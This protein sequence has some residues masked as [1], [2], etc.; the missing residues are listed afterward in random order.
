MTA[1]I[2][3]LTLGAPTVGTAQSVQPS[4]TTYT[5]L[6]EVVS[7][8]TT[9]RTMTVKPRVAYPEAASELKQFTP[10]ERVW[11]L[12]SGID[13][14]SD[15]VRQVR[16]AEPGR[17]IDQD[18]MLPAE[19]VSSEPAHQDVTIRVRVPESSLATVKAM[20]PGEWVTVTS[21]HHPSTDAEAVVTVVPYGANTSTN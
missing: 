6:G 7:S 4:A 17:Q 10:G 14:Y 1:T 12:W 20:K 8:D 9:A 16:R 15:A 11:V 5:W 2:A 19:F 13:N 21:R 3:V 18:L